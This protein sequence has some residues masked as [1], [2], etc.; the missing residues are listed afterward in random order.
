MSKGKCTVVASVCTMHSPSHA[1]TGDR[2]ASRETPVDRDPFGSPP[3]IGSRAGS[4]ASCTLDVFDMDCA[5]CAIQI[6]SA[7]CA[8]PGVT[9]SRVHFATQRARISYDPTRIDSASIARFIERLGFSVATTNA[10]TRDAAVREHRRRFLWRT[11]L[12]AFCAMQ[13]MMF[14][15]PR[16]LGG[17]DMEPLIGKLM[18]GAAFALT[19]PVLLF[20]VGSFFR[21]MQREW[22]MRRIGMDTAIAASLVVAFIGSVWHLWVQS[23]ALYFDSIAMFVAL[24]L[25]VRWWEWEQRERNRAAIEASASYDAIPIVCRVNQD[26]DNA[27]SEHVRAD[28]IEIG[29]R[30]VVSSG[31][32]LAVDAELCDA[33]TSCDESSLTGESRPVWK[34]RGDRLLAGTVNL[35]VAVTAR[36]V[37]TFDD[38][39]AN[40]LLRLADESA[41]REDESL[42]NRIGAYFL[43][44]VATIATITFVVC[45]PLGVAVALE[46]MVAVLIVSCPCALA[47]AAPAARARAFAQLLDLG[48]VM[49]RSESLDRLAKADAFVL[50]KTGTLTCPTAL[51]IEAIRD[52][53]DP[54]RAQAIIAALEFG[55]NHPLAHAVHTSFRKHLIKSSIIA[56]F[57]RTNNQVIGLIDNKEYRFGCPYKKG[58]DATSSSEKNDSARVSSDMLSLADSEGW[59][60]SVSVDEALRTG[61][62]A[63]VETLKHHG[64][65]AILSGDSE[66]RVHR[67]AESLDIADARAQCTPQGKAEYVHSL[68]R[69]GHIVAMIGDGVNDSIGFAGAD[70][71]IAAN[72]ALDRLR[73]SADIVCVK[74]D[75]SVIAKAVDYSKRVA[76]I[77]RQNYAWAIA[78][79]VIALPLAAFGFVNPV[80]AAIGMAASSAVVVLNVA[81]LRAQ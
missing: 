80:I 54:H 39:S 65:V 56:Q 44:V 67:I 16:Y 34:A 63:L 28:A 25:A 37:S 47:L 69:A 51:R 7:L 6:E 75:L 19:L 46:R 81:R 29:D 24:L 30:I 62:D 3:P 1:P 9:K 57:N 11:G 43:P 72:G 49:R 41:R 26:N 68:Q 58:D 14:S 10:A 23:G 17:A 64:T 32:A 27:M 33:W 4:I 79:N 76:R 77:V 35:G 21:C 52:G 38:S 73:A 59:I 48:I 12:A 45:F 2:S 61:A 55:S 18:D 13:I 8:A 74:E 78:Y 40:R 71:A 53:F 36:A 22:S 31:D 20:C 70:V 60:C 15:V 42:S 5:A 50:D 66:A